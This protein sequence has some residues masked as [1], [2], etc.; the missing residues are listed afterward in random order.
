VS[1]SLSSE[2]PAAAAYTKPLLRA[3]METSSRSNSTLLR[4]R[5]ARTMRANQF[6]IT[7]SAW[8]T[9]GHA[10]GDLVEG[11]ETGHPQAPTFAKIALKIARA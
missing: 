10:C 7:L 5:P 11:N 4:A 1:T 9:Y 8:R 3:C 2:M 6:R